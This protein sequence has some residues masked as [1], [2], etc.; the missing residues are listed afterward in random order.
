[1]LVVR[2][3]GRLTVER[4]G[5]ELD[6]PTSRRARGLL[7]WL[8]MYPDGRSRSQAAAAFWPDVPEASARSSL[9]GA[10]AELR[11]SLG[12]DADVLLADRERVGL[13]R[14]GVRVDLDDFDAHLLAGR[15]SD[16]LALDRGRLLSD[17]EDEWSHRR[18]EEHTR[19]VL[20]ALT[21]LAADLEADGAVAEAVPVAQRRVRLD[22]LSEKAGRELVRPLALAGD[23]AA[24]IEAGRALVERLQRELGVPPSAQTSGLLD[25]L[26]RDD[27]VAPTSTAPGRSG[28]VAGPSA[29][30]VR[31]L[32]APELLDRDVPLATLRELRRG[33]RPVAVLVDVVCPSG[34]CLGHG[35][36]TW[37]C[38]ACT[39][40]TASGPG[41]GDRLLTRPSLDP[42]VSSPGVTRLLG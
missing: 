18:R 36:P 42:E 20:R 37:I 22:P 11:R 6:L 35:D 27:P 40:R 3:L 24:A 13:D 5:T 39:G 21:R 32:V 16:A 26:R 2:V 15:W 30:R 17:V 19:D 1:M 9:R 31:D 38:W 10:L 4:D 29:P 12:D 14:A 34:P 7:A 23:R 28:V 33:P 8:A 41:Q 25:S